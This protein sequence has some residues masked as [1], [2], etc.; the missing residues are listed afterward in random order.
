MYACAMLMYQARCAVANKNKG[1]EFDSHAV[2]LFVKT[3]NYLLVLIELN[4]SELK[5]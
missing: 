2:D 5:G 1:V 3:L 4:T